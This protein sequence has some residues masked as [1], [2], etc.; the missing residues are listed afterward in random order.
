MPLLTAREEVELSRIIEAG[1]SAQ[2]RMRAGITA[3][4]DARASRAGVLAKEKIILANQRL[5][6]MVAE[7]YWS[8]ATMQFLEVIQEGNIGLALA[9]D[10]F[11]WRK[12]NKFAT[13]AKPKIRSA[14]LRALE[15]KKHL[16]RLPSRE[17][18]KHRAALRD[19]N[20]DRDTIGGEAG[21]QDRLTAP[22][23]LD[24]ILERESEDINEGIIA[25]PRTGPE[26][27]ALE[28]FNNYTMEDLLD[29]LTP[30]ER[31]VLELRYDENGETLRTYAEIGELL[32]C[33]GSNV[34]AI[35]KRIKNTLRT[36]GL[37]ILR[38]LMGED[39]LEA[40]S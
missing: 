1:N 29:L 3:Y 12:G 36:K 31:L 26:E 24:V 33:T 40:V 9:V 13:F 6:Y 19:H 10:S 34:H 25:D 39:W 18:Y 21:R 22:T 32:D 7:R 30:R 17:F 11:D 4:D 16:V 2:A 28:G 20:D 5:V 27:E 14:I 23:S 38:D 15:Q 35:E 37:T 8:T